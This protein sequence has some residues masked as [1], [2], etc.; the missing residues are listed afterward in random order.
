MGSVQ[1]EVISSKITLHVK[2]SLNCQ[3][4]KL[5]AL[6]KSNGWGET[7]ATDRTSGAD[8]C[9]KNVLA[10]GIDVSV[11]KRVEVHVGWLLSIRTI[12]SMTSINDW[13]EELRENLIGLLVASN[14]P[15]SLDVR[16]PGVVNTSFDDVREGSSGDGGTLLEF[17]VQFWGEGLGHEVVVLA[18]VG[19]LFWRLVI[20]PESGILLG[21][22]V[23]S[24]ATPELDPLWES[25]DAL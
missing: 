18:E 11:G 19:H 22:V 10:L 4:F 25:L 13:I 7:E 16:M 2:K 15:A 14:D 12:S 8:T 21:T 5:T 17:V 9:G 23:W 1:W 6:L 24:V 3:S 20:N